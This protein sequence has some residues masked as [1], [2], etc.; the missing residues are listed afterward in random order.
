ML[1]RLIRR[2]QNQLGGAPL[3]DDPDRFTPLNRMEKW[4]IMAR[5]K[6]FGLMRAR[7]TRAGGPGYSSRRWRPY[8]SSRISCPP[9]PS[10]A[11]TTLRKIV[12]QEGRARRAY[13]HRSRHQGPQANRVQY[14]RSYR[15]P[16]RPP[17]RPVASL[18]LLTTSL[19]SAAARQ[20]SPSPIQSTYRFW[21]RP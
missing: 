11:R 19:T 20:A 3:Y 9:G 18:A 7:K 5:L 13:R 21:Q 2:Q 16:R 4:V 12:D 8:A 6:Y 14:Q 1:V 15:S 10:F 17:R